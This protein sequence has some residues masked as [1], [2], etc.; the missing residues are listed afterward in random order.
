MAEQLL[1]KLL[2]QVLGSGVLRLKE[3]IFLVY[4]DSLFL[5][6]LG[7]KIGRKKMNE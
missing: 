1:L 2:L 5:L 6:H 3:K 4:R 7:K